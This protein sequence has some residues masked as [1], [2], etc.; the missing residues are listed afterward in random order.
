MS[1]RYSKF[2]A[3]VFGVIF[4]SP[5]LLLAFNNNLALIPPMGWNDWN[6][7]HCGIDES[8]AASGMKSAGYQFININN[9]WAGSLV[10][11]GKLEVQ[12]NEP[13]KTHK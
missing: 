11:N 2:F 13:D 9:D 12:S 6:S 1:F 7:Y 3:S 10:V 4:S 5:R 8:G